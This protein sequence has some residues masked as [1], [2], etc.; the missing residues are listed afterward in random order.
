MSAARKSL[1]DTRSGC[2]RVQRGSLALTKGYGHIDANTFGFSH[3]VVAVYK[4]QQSG[5]N[6]SGSKTHKNQEPRL[7]ALNIDKRSGAKLDGWPDAMQTK[8]GGQTE[9]RSG[10]WSY[11]L[12]YEIHLNLTVYPAI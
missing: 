6:S 5:S 9:I 3:L 1:L 7:M 11:D 4:G 2:I 8:S 10:V 12:M